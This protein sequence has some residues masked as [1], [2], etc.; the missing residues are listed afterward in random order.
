M[1]EGNEK[2][3]TMQGGKHGKKGSW[4][5]HTRQ[6]DPTRLEGVSRE[7]QQGV[8]CTKIDPNP[9][10]TITKAREKARQKE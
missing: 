3:G 10:K 5:N 7:S 8:I 1:M 6:S 2:R 4:T 9:R